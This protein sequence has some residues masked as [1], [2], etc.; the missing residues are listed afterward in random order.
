MELLCTENDLSSQQRRTRR[1]AFLF[2]GLC[3]FTLIFFVVLC[4]LVNTANAAR[5]LRLALIGMVLLGWLCIAVRV[6]LLSPARA[7]RSHLEGLLSQAPSLRE[8]RFFLTADSFQIPKSVLVRRVRLEGAEETVSLNLDEAWTSRAPENGSLVRVQTVRKFITGIEVLA[9]PESPPAE[10]DRTVPG[11]RF[12]RVFSRLFP[13][14][15]LC[16]VL[17]PIFTGFVFTRITDTD[18]AHKVTVYADTKLQNA[19]LLA[20]RLEEAVSAPVRMVK[21]HPFTYA[22][23]GSDALKQADLYIVPLSHVSEYRDWFAPLPKELASRAASENPDGIRVFDPA[24]GTGAASSC[25]LYTASGAQPEPYLLF[26]GRNSVHL[27]DHAALDVA[28]A[29]LSLTGRG[30]SENDTNSVK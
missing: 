20:S 28:G 1:C 13:L 16:A 21:V 15:V 25:I 26:F 17:I 8:G 22:L 27:E 9:P 24:S 12:R 6:C 3:L 19:A 30:S 5:M 4:L 18:P 7:K 14:F 10:T 2:Y 23:F 11:K 29:L